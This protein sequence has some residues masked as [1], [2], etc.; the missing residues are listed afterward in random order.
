MEA[1]PRLLMI[2]IDLKEF[3]DY[4]ATDWMDGIATD[5]TIQDAI[6]EQINKVGI[7]RLNFYVSKRRPG[8]RMKLFNGFLD[9]KK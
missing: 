9:V 3:Q 1:V 4:A 8:S 5:E 2:K 7:L 6:R